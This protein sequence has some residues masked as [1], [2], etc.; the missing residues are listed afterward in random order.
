VSGPL[1]GINIKYLRGVYIRR[2]RYPQPKP[3]RSGLSLR[4]PPQARHTSPSLSG[5]HLAGNS[6]QTIPPVCQV[7]LD[8]ADS[9]AQNMLQDSD[10]E[11][12]QDDEDEDEGS[13]DLNDDGESPH[14]L[15]RPI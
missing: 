12:E 1:T 8:A 4:I 2:G 3:S 5:D 15:N 10:S 7:E 14:L 13:W 11:G 9:T 6:P